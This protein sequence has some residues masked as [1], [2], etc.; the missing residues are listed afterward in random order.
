MVVALWRMQHTGHE[1]QV[2]RDGVHLLQGIH[3]DLEMC[4]YTC[5]L[6]MGHVGLMLSS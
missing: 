3:H 4:R 2:E 1:D 6:E 5:H